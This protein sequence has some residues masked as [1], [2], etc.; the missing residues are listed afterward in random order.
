MLMLFACVA[1]AC[2]LTTLAQGTAPAAKKASLT[3]EDLYSDANVVSAHISPSG[4]SIA[5]AVNRGG[6]R[7]FSRLNKS[8]K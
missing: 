4:K 1:L 5:A 6:R 8:A 3:L 2:P 7:L